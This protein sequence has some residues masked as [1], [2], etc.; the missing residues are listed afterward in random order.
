MPSTMFKN[1]PQE[2]L[3]RVTCRNTLD[4]WFPP[5]NAV[6]ICTAQAVAVGALNI[7]GLAVKSLVINGRCV[8]V[9]PSC[10]VFTFTQ[11]TDNCVIEMKGTNQWGEPVTWI[12]SKPATGTV[13]KT[14]TQAGP[15][16]PPMWTID[17]IRITAVTVGAGTVSVGWNYSSG[18]TQS[19]ALPVAYNAVADIGTLT[20]AI[21]V[22]QLDGF[23]TGGPWPG[24]PTLAFSNPVDVQ[25]GVIGIIIGA[26]TASST[27]AIS[28]N[29]NFTAGGWVAGTLTL[30]KVA[31]FAGYEFTAGDTITVV[32]GTGSTPG[33]YAIASKVD[34]D[35]ITLAISPGADAANYVFRINQ[36]ATAGFFLFKTGAFTGLSSAPG[37]TITLTG[38]TGIRPG[39]YQ[40]LAKRSANLILL[41]TD[42]GGTNATDVAFTISASNTAWGRM[43]L[44]LPPE[45]LVTK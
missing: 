6:G 33:T 31:A 20:R 16:I 32:S 18:T 3:N 10:P 43:T 34:N 23:W 30:T 36:G 2:G 24:F 28:T 7:D 26:T 27:T 40:V 11:A 9:K 25:R 1:G 22:E 17:S 8:L 41:A 13:I 42:P 5:E 35:S 19:I 21:Y 14:L 45:L 38:G 15:R 37:Q 44:V 12:I 39:T 4:M 29:A